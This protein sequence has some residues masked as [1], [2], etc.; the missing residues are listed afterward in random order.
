MYVIASVYGN[1]HC[2]KIVRIRSYP[3]PNSVRMRKNTDQ[4]NSEYGHILPSALVLYY[5]QNFEISVTKTIKCLCDACI[6]WRF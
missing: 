5:F 3:G 1:H 2:V 6:T 4:N